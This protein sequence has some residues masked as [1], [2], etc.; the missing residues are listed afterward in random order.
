MKEGKVGKGLIQEQGMK[1]Y[2]PGL[3]L[4]WC[5]KLLYIALFKDKSQSNEKAYRSHASSSTN[6][7]QNHALSFKYL[8][9]FSELFLCYFQY[10][11]A[12]NNNNK[13]TEFS[14]ITCTFVTTLIAI[15]VNWHTGIHRV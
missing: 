2:G 6:E 1:E 15:S 5:H 12:I 4:G 11:Q 3:I 8:P 13:Q 9:E 10:Y 7:R 14:S